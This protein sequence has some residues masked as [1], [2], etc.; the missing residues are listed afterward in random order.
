MWQA[1]SPSR[2]DR[3][4]AVS[5]RNSKGTDKLKTM[6][7]PCAHGFFFLRC[8]PSR[9]FHQECVGCSSFRRQAAMQCLP[10]PS[11]RRYRGSHS[12][13]RSGPSVLL[14]SRWTRG[15][16]RSSHPGPRL[17][18]R[19]TGCYSARPCPR[20]SCSPSS[21][22]YTTSGSRFV[23]CSTGCGRCRSARR[24]SSSTT[25][26]TDGTRDIAPRARGG[27]G[28]DR[29]IGCAPCS[30]IRVNA[31]KGAACAPASPQ[32]SGDIALI[33]DADLEYDPNEYPTLIEPIVDGD[34]DVVFGSRFLGS[35]TA[36]CSSATP[37]QHAADLLS[38]LCTDLNLTDMETCY[39]VFRADVLRRL[40][41]TS[42]RFG[43]EP[44]ITAKVARLGCRV[45]EVPISYHGR[46]YW[47][48]K[49]IGWRD[50]VH[51]HLDDPP[52]RLDRRPG[53]HRRRATGRC[54]GCTPC[55]AITSACGPAFRRTS[56]TAC[57]R[58]AAPS[59]TTRASCASARTSSWRTTTRVGLDAA[60]GYERFDNIEVRHLD[61]NDPTLGGLVAHRFDTVLC[62][63]I[64]EHLENDDAR[65]ARCSRCCS[66]AAAWCS[67]PRPAPALRRAR[68][69]LG[70]QRRYER[71]EVERKLRAQ[72]LEI[73]ELCYFNLPGALLWYLDSRLLER[74]T[75]PPSRT[76]LANLALP[77]LRR[78]KRLRPGWGMALVAAAR[79][80]A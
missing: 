69:R 79:K 1:R 58:S 40:H 39:K 66:R 16:P 26:S 61:W 80:P 48:G 10:A 7:S 41:L 76:R 35:R 70:H 45:Y 68:S 73:E 36:S 5:P 47:E 4:V 25:A 12:V 32:V 19:W 49:K 75:V 6:G 3:G 52:V 63:N 20:T 38:N 24:S 28:D 33:Q 34:A 14:K 71:D 77:W 72:G 18:C 2:T 17:S 29:R 43:I 64:L 78:E 8:L 55:A 59:A 27:A 56:A 42:N 67:R 46:E 44:E 57:S 62:P 11:P 31:G 65:P 50:G 9:A 51:G 74:H 23:S 37:G 60:H 21:F 30:T 13:N 15:Q 54:G 22:P 53:A